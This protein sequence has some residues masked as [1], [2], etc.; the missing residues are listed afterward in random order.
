MKEKLNLFQKLNEIQ[1]KVKTVNKGASVSTGKGGGSYMAVSHD[2]VAALLHLP[3]AEAGIFVTI[4][5]T[6]A[7]IEK[8]ETE[9][10]YN[11]Q[12]SVKLSYKASVWVCATFINS[13]SPEEKFSVNGF[14]YS[15]DNSDKATGKALS[16]AVK[17]M[18]LKQFNLESVDNEESRD[19]E[20]S[21]E[22]NRYNNPAPQ[23]NRQAP[24]PQT[25]QAN[26]NVAASAAQ[27]GLINRIM[28]EVNTN[29]MTKQKA[30]ELIQAHNNKPKN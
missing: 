29:G 14:A 5:I 15:M 8:I 30:S 11:G 20:A 28:P 22:T 2:D 9:S 26:N 1:K 19:W 25:S 27:I 12:R 17:N 4:D 13:D 6:K 3:L 24:A 18:Y 7:E 16:Y 21:R 10:E 23:A